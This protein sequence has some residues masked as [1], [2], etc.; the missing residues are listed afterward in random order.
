MSPNPTLVHLMETADFSD[1]IIRCHAHDFQVHKAIVCGQSPVIKAAV[2][3]NFEESQRNIITMHSF[4]PDTVKRLVQFMYT[5]DYDDRDPPKADPSVDEEILEERTSAGATS[6]VHGTDESSTESLSEDVD[7]PP[8]E[9]VSAQ[10]LLEH[11]CV[12]SIGDYYQIAG[13]VSLANNKISRLLQEH[14]EDQ[15]WVAMLPTATG[16]ALQSTGDSELLDILAAATAS[17]ISSLVESSQ[18]KSLDVVT[19]F[20]FKVLQSSN[21]ATKQA[22]KFQ[23]S[24]LSRNIDENQILQ[25]H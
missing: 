22:R 10:N 4:Q 6:E 18:L 12:N 25:E 19:D 21:V 20:T 23:D 2:Q 7:L 24:E 14:R 15:S 17:N 13:L 1:L 8:Q 16:A 11:I 5:G 9:Y 3:G